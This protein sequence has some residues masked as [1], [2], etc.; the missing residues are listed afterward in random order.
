MVLIG[1]SKCLANVHGWESPWVCAGFEPA[2]WEDGLAPGNES[3][4]A[5]VPEVLT[6]TWGQQQGL[7]LSPLASS[8]VI[9]PL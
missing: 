2:A 4:S 8:A 7:A 5:T 6:L 1:S 9:C 3:Q